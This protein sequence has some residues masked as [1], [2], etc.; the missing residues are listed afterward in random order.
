MDVLPPLH[1][2][3]TQVEAIWLL[4]CYQY[5]QLGQY[6]GALTDPKVLVALNTL[7]Q[8]LDMAGRTIHQRNAGERKGREYMY[9][10]PTRIPN[11]TN[12]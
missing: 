11:S 12:I 10:S 7:H 2:A 8:H 6:G 3:H 1:T 5:G 9:L 4:T